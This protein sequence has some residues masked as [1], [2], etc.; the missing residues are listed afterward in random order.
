MNIIKIKDL[1]KIPKNYTGIAE[2][3]DGTKYWYKDGEL[4][5][6]DGPA[7]E[8]LNGTKYWYKNN[9]RHRED[10]PAV[11]YSDGEKHWYKNGLF[12]RE[13]GPA[14]EYLSG[15]KQWFKNGKRHRLDGPAVEYSDESSLWFFE[16]QEYEQL[17]LNDYVILDSYQGRYGIMWYKLLGKDKIIE[18]PDIPGLIK[19]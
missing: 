8:Y 14:I 9:Y 19:K 4:H 12:H 18:Y 2:R 5:R 6:E 7:V 10:G 1:L 17:N 13:D 16:D 15:T 3:P 11:E